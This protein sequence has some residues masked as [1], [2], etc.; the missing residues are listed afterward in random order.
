M[1]LQRKVIVRVNPKNYKS[2]KNYNFSNIGDFIEIDI[3]DLSKNSHLI[4]ECECDVCGNKKNIQYKSY[5]SSI[6]KYNY[7]TCSSKCAITKNK[8]T[9][10]LNIG[11]LYPAQD[12]RVRDKYKNTMLEKY[13]VD[14]SLKIEGVNQLAVERSKN[15]RS[16]EK[17]K[18]TNE[19]KWGS[20]KRVH[21]SRYRKSNINTKFTEAQQMKLNDIDRIWDCGKIKFEKNK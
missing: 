5:V 3:C 9:N 4:V 1:L 2:L 19:I 8:K 13:G 15:I 7:Y 11:Y 14:N 10:L 18:N 20:N 6:S 12:Q 16:K 17:R 21:K